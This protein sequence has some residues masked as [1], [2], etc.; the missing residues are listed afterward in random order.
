MSGSGFRT[1]LHPVVLSGAVWFAISVAGVVT[2]IIVR[3]D[4]AAGPTRQLVLAGAAIA[5]LGFVAPI[6][7]W[8][9]SEL[10]VTAEGVRV[11]TG[12]LRVHETV[13]AHEAVDAVETSS[14]LVGRLLDYGTVRIVGADGTW[15]ELPRV[16]RAAAFRD[17][18]RAASPGSRRRRSSR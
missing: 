2:L 16:A 1:R 11:R 5:A 17:A 8:R 6:V 13:L 18:A 15:E 12:F 14:T 9:R 10:A 7:R 4:L 3:N